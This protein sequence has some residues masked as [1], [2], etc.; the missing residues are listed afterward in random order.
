[1]HFCATPASWQ[2]DRKQKLVSQAGL[3]QIVDLTGSPAKSRDVETRQL[4]VSVT[5][6]AP[7]YRTHDAVR[8]AAARRALRMSRAAP[9][10]NL[11]AKRRTGS[12]AAAA[13]SNR[14][15]RFTP[16]SCRASPPGIISSA[17]HPALCPFYFSSIISCAARRSLDGWG[18]RLVRCRN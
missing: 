9:H 4:G 6:D 14:N 16:E 7:L 18:T 8:K 5:K 2:Y 12:L 1:M 13:R 10:R 17:H 11:V 15:V 3:L